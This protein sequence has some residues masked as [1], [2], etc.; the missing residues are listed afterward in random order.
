MMTEFAFFPI[1]CFFNDKQCVQEMRLSL[2]LA[3]YFY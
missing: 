2:D 1:S 3:L